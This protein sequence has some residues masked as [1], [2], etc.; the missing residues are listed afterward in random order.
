[1]KDS[2]VFLSDGYKYTHWNQYPKGTTNIYSYLESRGGDFDA[3]A[4]FGLQGILKEHL[5]GQVLTSQDIFEALPFFQD[6]FGGQKLF[7]EYG[8]F[9]MLEKHGGQLPVS[10]KAV[11]EGTVVPTRNVLMTVEN[12]DEEFPWLTNFLE[13]LLLHVWYPTTVCTLSREIKKVF[14]KNLALSGGDP[15]VA[16]FMLNDF[17]FRGVSSVE[18][19]QAGGAAHLVN[20][21]GTDTVQGVRYAMKMYGADVCGGSIPATEHSV[22]TLR[23]R[24]GE[25]AQVDLLL[26]Q[27]PTGLVACVGDSYSIFNFIDTILRDRRERILAR[28]GVVI[29]R[30]DSGDPI[31][32]SVEVLTR[33]ASVFGY[34]K[35]KKGFVVLPPQVRAI[36]G[37]G[38]NYDS[39]GEIQNAI[40][41]AGFAVENL[42]FGMG[43][44]LLQGVNRDTQKFATKAA[45]AIIDEERYDVYKDPI[46]DP[47]KRSKRG[48]MKLVRTTDTGTGL[49]TVPAHAE[50]EDQLVEVF[51]DGELL[52]DQSF[53]EVRGRAALKY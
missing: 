5:V 33:L 47:G 27:N 44:A 28:E 49:T 2:I 39:I 38:I 51:R 21:R 10:I 26:D 13:S 34:F 7:N 12:T 23:G 15:S 19:S 50:G 24:E 3:T 45:E 36:Y 32:M 48:R 35:N 22:M 41:A 11:P 4:F 18:S 29:T 25:A 20:F 40:M 1:M 37:D 53:N 14:L 9:R 17:G 31:Q 52:V 43:G 42:A 8:W 46:T 6:Y 30:P 16:D